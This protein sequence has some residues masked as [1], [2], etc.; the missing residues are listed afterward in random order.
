[1]RSRRDRT[2]RRTGLFWLLLVAAAGFGFVTTQAFTASNAVPATN[3]GQFTQAIAPS[4]LE[5][6]ECLSGGITVTSIVAG[7]G[8][9]TSTAAGQLVLGSSGVDT[10]N[11]NSFGLDCMVG[12]AGADSFN[13]LNKGGDLCVV[14]AAT[15]VPNIKKCTVVATRP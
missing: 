12:G 3:I 7:A 13:G 10:L 4:Q 14:S 8:T 5:P 11:D 6:A 15:T 1:M 9:I 2:R